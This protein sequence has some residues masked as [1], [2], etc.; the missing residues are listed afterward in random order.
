MTAVAC[1][2]LTS[3]LIATRPEDDLLSSFKAGRQRQDG[4][5]K[6]CPEKGDRKQT[7]SAKGTNPLAF[8]TLPLTQLRAAVLVSG[9]AL[10]LGEEARRPR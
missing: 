9:S 3:G 10:A 2:Q 1:L 6:G 5:G 8:A 4:K 7:K